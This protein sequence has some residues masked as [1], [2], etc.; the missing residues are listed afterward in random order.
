MEILLITGVAITCISILVF[1]ILMVCEVDV[2]SLPIR[3]TSGIS[4]VGLVLIMIL[5]VIMVI[6]SSHNCHC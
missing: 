3:I 1:A 5:L 2:D 6:I 4:I